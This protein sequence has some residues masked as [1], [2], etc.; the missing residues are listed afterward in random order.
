V[1]S[2]SIETGV[3]V[4][5]SRA[6]ILVHDAGENLDQI[7]LAPLG[8]KA[9]LARLALVHPVLQPGFREPDPGRAAVNDTAQRR[10]VALAP[11]GHAEQVAESVVRHALQP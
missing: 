11:G 9:R 2:I 5:T 7:V 6:I 4:V 10:P 8:D 1:F 3:P